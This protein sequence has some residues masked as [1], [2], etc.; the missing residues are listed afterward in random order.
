MYILSLSIIVKQPNVLSILTKSNS[1][2][3]SFKT[4]TVVLKIID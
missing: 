2:D 3:Q 1:V 4:V